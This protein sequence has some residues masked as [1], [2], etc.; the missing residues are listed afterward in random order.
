MSSTQS[1]SVTTAEKPAAAGFITNIQQKDPALLP[2]CSKMT[3]DEAKK[4]GISRN[5]WRKQKRIADKLEKRPIKRQ[6]ER[7]RKKSQRKLE[8]ENG[9]FQPKPQKYRMSESSNKVRIA[10]DLSF[11]DYMVLADTRNALTQVGYCYSSNRKTPNPFQFYA[12]GVDDKVTEIAKSI[13][14]FDHWDMHIKPEKIDKVFNKSE[15]VY[16]CAESDNVLEE[17]DETKVYI[18]GGLVDHNH[19]KGLCYGIAQENGYGHARLPIEENMKLD[20]RKVLTINHVFD[21][22]VNYYVTKDW[23]KALLTVIPERKRKLPNDNQKDTNNKELKLECDGD[24]TTDD[25]E[26]G[27]EDTVE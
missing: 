16:L 23:K 9:T 24:N 27:K 1:S 7:E 21:I 14:V 11:S 22:L 6:E 17:F 2:D 20:S 5:Q 25:D 13:G 19:H 3:W 18:I 26:A 15:V 12:C 4:T 10:I 8:K